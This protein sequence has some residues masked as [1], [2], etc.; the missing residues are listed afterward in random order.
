MQIPILSGI[1]SD[2]TADFRTSYPINAM[3][4]PKDTG[5]AKGYL[6][7]ADGL[8]EFAEGPDVDRGGIEWQGFCYRVMGTKLVRVNQGG[9]VDVLGDVG[10]GTVALSQRVSMDYSFDRL[11]IASGGRLYYWD[12]AT[13]TQVTDPDL[14]VVLDVMFISGYFMTTDGENVVVTDLA[15]PFAVNPLKYGSSEFDPDPVLALFK[16]RNEAYVLNRYTIEVFDN[17]GGNLFPFQTIQGAEI[18]KGVIGT[19]M[20]CE[21][22]GSFAFVGSG[23]G[24]QGPEPPAVYIAG[25]GAA[26]KISTREID[27]ILSEYSEYD[28]SLGSMEYR[29]FEGHQLL[30]IHLSDRTVVHDIAASQAVGESVWFTLTSD[31]DCVGPYRARNFVY[32]YGKWLCGDIYDGRIGEI[33]RTTFAQYEETMGYQFE[34]GLVYNEGRGAIINS[35]ELVGLPGRAGLT[36]TPV[37]FNSYSDDGLQFSQEK[38]VSA[39]RAGQTGQ[40]IQWRRQGRMRLFRL[41]RFRGVSRSHIAFSR[42]EAEMEPLNA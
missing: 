21:V 35:L 23:R 31:I 13:L 27:R 12:G 2:D 17:I 10:A 22:S 38:A 25:G 11:A 8:T 41:Q 19:H 24:K 30:Y 3:A 5:I 16:L 7:T 1:Y 9:T 36:E 39:G 42:L 14:G 18:P 20:R 28:L 32:C 33:D 6:R 4:V 40:R 37:V 34:A 29:A 15:D 26:V